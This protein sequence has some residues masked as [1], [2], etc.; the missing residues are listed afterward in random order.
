MKNRCP[1]IKKSLISKR[2]KRNKRLLDRRKVNKDIAFIKSKKINNFYVAKKDYNRVF[3]KYDLL[4]QL[5]IEFDYG[6]VDDTETLKL[7]K[8]I[9]ENGSESMAQSNETVK[10]RSNNKNSKSKKKNTFSKKKIFL[11]IIGIIVLIGM[12][13][14]SYLLILFY[15]DYKAIEDVNDSNFYTSGTSVN[16]YDRNNEFLTSLSEKQT[17]WVDLCADG[18]TDCGTTGAYNISP[19]YVNALIDTED[20]NYY[21][22]GPINIIGLIKAT[23]LTL[24][25]G[26]EGRGGSTLTMQLGKILYMAD[27]WVYTYYYPDG[28][29]PDPN[30]PTDLPRSKSE[31]EPINYKFT[32]M[33]Y[34]IK[35]E[36]KY[37]KEQI[38]ENLVNVMYFGYGKY[39]IQ[40][41]SQY[42]FGVDAKDLNLVQGATLAGITQSPSFYDPYTNQDGV[43]QRRSDVLLSMLNNGDI[44]QEEFDAAD[45]IPLS[46]YIVNHGESSTD[47]SAQNYTRN[48]AY[49]EVVYNELMGIFDPEGTGDFDP[50]NAGLKIYTA[51]DQEMQK[52]TYNAI[53]NDDYYSDDYQQ[54]GSASIDTQTGQI[55][56]IGGGRGERGID[57]DQ[58]YAYTYYRQPGSTAKPIVDYA[59]AIE[60]L[61]WSTAHVVPDKKIT[62]TGT[63]TVVNDYDM[64]YMGDLSLGNA[65]AGSRN[66]TALYTLQQLNKEVGVEKVRLFVQSLGITD[67]DADH[68][69][70]AYSIGGWDTGTTPLELAGAYSTFANGGIYNKP[71]AI[72]KIEIDPS[73]PY[74]EKYGAEYI[75]EYESTRVMS[76]E[77]AYMMTTMLNV[78]NPGALTT[79]ADF[80]SNN[81]L[82]AKSGTSNWAAN[83]YGIKEGTERDKWLSGFTPDV[84]TAVW[85]GYP[86]NMETKGYA[87]AGAARNPQWIFKE[88]ME[89]TMTSSETYLHD[90]TYKKP[91]TV[92]SAKIKPNV[93]PPVKDDKGQVFYFIKGSD[94]YNLLENTFSK[95]KAKAPTVNAQVKNQNVLLTWDYEGDFRD[96]AK[97]EITVDG[98]QYK[99]TTEM[100]L[101]IP[102]SDFATKNNCNPSYNIGVQLVETNKQNQT[103]V[104][105]VVNSKVVITADDYCKK[106]TTPVD[107]DEDGLD[108][109]TENSIGTDPK[110]P[111]SDGDTLS[112]GDEVNTYNTD[113]LNKDSD[114]D[115]YSD[116]DEIA[117]S[118]DPNDPASVPTKT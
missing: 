71:H 17:T 39:G 45:A 100:S 56:A 82:C 30:D 11:I 49:Y 77:T 31:Y 18:K 91:D 95:D 83:P 102:F 92:V 14:A 20:K 50:H 62:Y 4:S 98:K 32:Q 44:T 16:I 60:F 80:A 108:D 57:Y 93:W 9:N 73:S 36:K 115:T 72:T 111:D 6:T 118:T 66:A 35:I 75:P 76:E 114:N 27:E 5:D 51:L 85:F 103:R 23:I 34:A 104:S 10:K 26:L 43:T 67:T 79:D 70:E 68:F 107:T 78:K 40:N 97:W 65:L 90:N 42:Y 7:T 113:P 19:N 53:N 8:D 61:K 2:K 63:D 1:K 74:Y 37:S 110:N 69:N 109:A 33:S 87:P 38:L 24:T 54:A 96:T 94:D 84:A 13:F 116:A 117:A 22:H 58:N 99:E 25:P 3:N 101:S 15:K 12:I 89:P 46:D 41:A 47:E 88:I 21:K 28:Y 55:L 64:N 59:P 81:T 112:D 105:D 29:T 106:I 48:V 52:N 86:G